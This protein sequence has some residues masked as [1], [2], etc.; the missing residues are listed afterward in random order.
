MVFQSTE[1]VKKRAECKIV[2]GV[3]EGERQKTPEMVHRTEEHDLH[4]G[5]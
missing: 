4:A 2:D 3:Q 5:A 1:E